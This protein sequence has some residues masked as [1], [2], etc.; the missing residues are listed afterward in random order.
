MQ[1]NKMFLMLPVMF[2]ARKI[3]A[4]DPNVIYWLRVAYAVIQVA[5]ILVVA[6]VY[7][8]SMAV[9]GRSSIVYVPP[10]PMVSLSLYRIPATTETVANHDKNQCYIVWI[11]VSRLFMIYID[12]LSLWAVLTSDV[13]V[14]STAFCRPKCQE[15][16]HRSCL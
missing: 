5:C 1:F 7:Y 2:A 9:A 15:K 13:I 16:V 12:A 6:F 14:S 3:D 4:E 10:P 8:H 11:V